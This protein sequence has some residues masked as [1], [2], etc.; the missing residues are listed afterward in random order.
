MRAIVQSMPLS[1]LELATLDEMAQWWY[2]V[3]NHGSV[4]F[5]RKML[6]DPPYR[7]NVTAAYWAAYFER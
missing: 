3:G 4:A 6:D 1:D 5:I 7:K 2:Q